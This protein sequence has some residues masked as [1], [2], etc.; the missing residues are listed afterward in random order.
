[1]GN[2]NNTEFISKGGMIC[3][4][5]QFCKYSDVGVHNK[6]YGAILMAELD[7]VCA[8][9]AAEILDTPWIVTK[10]MNV[11]FISSINPNQMYKT[12]VGIEKIGNTSI[13]L[14]AEIR[15]HSVHTEVETLAVKANTI[16]VRINEEGEAILISDYIRKKFGYEPLLK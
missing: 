11:E 1:M 12:Y 4:N 5:T 10:T 16:F 7:S 8:A 3:R 14:K 9:F 6:I 15:R 2:Q 13:T